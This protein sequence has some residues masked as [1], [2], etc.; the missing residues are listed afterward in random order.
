MAETINGSGSAEEFFEL[1]PT[2]LQTLSPEECQEYNRKLAA[3]QARQAEQ[4]VVDGEPRPIGTETLREKMLV[5]LPNLEPSVERYQGVIPENPDEWVGT[6]IEA[7]TGRIKLDKDQLEGL[8]K[9]AIYWV[10]LNRQRALYQEAFLQNLPDD[11]ARV[12][13]IIGEIKLLQDSL[14]EPGQYDQE[15]RYTFLWQF[16]N[17]DPLPDSEMLRKLFEN[18]R[19]ESLKHDLRIDLQKAGIEPLW[20]K[21]RLPK[22]KERRSEF[23]EEAARRQ[24]KEQQNIMIPTANPGLNGQI[25]K[26]LVRG[27]QQNDKVLQPAVVM[28]YEY[29]SADT[30]DYKQ[31]FLNRLGFVN[32]WI[33]NTLSRADERA[34]L[35]GLT[36]EGEEKRKALQDA[37]QSDPPSLRCYGFLTGV[38]LATRNDPEIRAGAQGFR[39]RLE[40]L[41]IKMFEGDQQIRQES[42]FRRAGFDDCEIVGTA[43]SPPEVNNFS[44]A[45]TETPG[46]KVGEE[47]ALKAKVVTFSSDYDARV[48]RGI[49]GIGTPRFLCKPYRS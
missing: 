25:A 30:S 13:Q 26:V 10:A 29:R 35:Y 23:E 46:F 12:E 32:K 47:A 40:S 20:P 41:G 18:E 27:V 45:F 24:Q 33:N 15:Q 34:Q 7:E 9:N 21:N 6:I 14:G 38:P 11:E 37:I 17:Q 48:P 8:P 3:H 31:Q 16:A 49:F 19:M 39:E 36:G 5:N 28:M 43:W 1:L 44:I 2:D 22:S 42:P 4:Q